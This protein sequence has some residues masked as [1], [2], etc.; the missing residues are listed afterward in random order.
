MKITFLGTGGA[1]FVTITQIRAT[2]GWILW[3]DGEMMH[4]DPGPGALVRAKQYGVNLRKL[5]GIVISHVHPDHTTD[6]P[7]VLEAMTQG[8][9]KKRGVVL[10]N[11]HAFR[12]GENL[13]PVFSEYHLKMLERHEVME[14]G[15][16][17][18]VGKVSV[19]AVEARHTE[20]K[21]LGYV[22][23]GEGKKVGYTGDGEYY[24]GQEK[25]FLGCDVL[26]INCHR[27]KEFPLKGYMDSEGARKLIEKAKPGTAILTHF[28]IRM[29]RGVAEREAKWIGQETG[30]RTI[31]AKDGMVI[32]SG[33][34]ENERGGLGRFI[35]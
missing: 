27:P 28:G 5:T 26:L 6:A 32:D 22:F 23:S 4:V 1:R 15:K 13:V 33:K 25:H 11:G 7:V 10:A 8:A 20:P 18:R 17:A 3:L 16:K 31:A 34:K 30:V 19:E 12:G 14:P 24:D 2:G 29:M 21:A 35:D 9:L